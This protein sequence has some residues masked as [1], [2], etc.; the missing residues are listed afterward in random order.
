MKKLFSIVLIFAILC[1]T[2][3]CLFACNTPDNTPDNADNL[4]DSQEIYVDYS[5]DNTFE[6]EV[7]EDADAVTYTPVGATAK[8]GLLFYVG[9]VI[10]PQSYAYLSEPLAKQGYVVVIS[11]L[12]FAYIQYKETETT[13]EKY[14][15][16]EFFIGGH[17]QGGGAAV[18]RTQENIGSVK[19]VIL[20]APLC[21]APDTIADASV[22]TLLIEATKDGVLNYTQKED[23]KSRLPKNR[24]EYKINGC[25]MSFSSLD[26]DAMLA[27]F[28]DGPVTDEERATQ[29]EMTS[30]YTLAFMK[31]V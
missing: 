10:P 27:P 14:P 23:A 2:A 12:L 18:K 26:N 17:S 3:F 25:H 29:K 9:T 5:K 6:F 11:K 22:P 8:Y 16:I 20:Y 13:F 21:F 15:N 4:P 31:S 1:L 19:G 28:N 30:A 7:T 24:T